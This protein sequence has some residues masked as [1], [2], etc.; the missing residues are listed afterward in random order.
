[1]TEEEFHGI[2]LELEL[3]ADGLRVVGGDGDMPPEVM[4]ELHD[5]LHRAT[6][7]GISRQIRRYVTPEIANHV[8]SAYGDEEASMPSL[9]VSALITLIRTCHISDE[10][11]M[12][13]LNEA[14]PVFHGYVL[15]TTLLGEGEDRSGMPVLRKLAGL[16][17][18]DD[19][20]AGP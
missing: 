6:V 17:P 9:A 14:S 16:D 4:E 10:Q 1:M 7:Q 19:V 3:T 8:L 20:K 12:E 5:L 15:A 11:M 13:V 18:D 2:A